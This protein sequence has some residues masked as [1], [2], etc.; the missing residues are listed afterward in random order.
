MKKNS[1]H[2]KMPLSSNFIVAKGSERDNLKITLA[3]K[4][5]ARKNPLGFKGFKSINEEK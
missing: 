3:G 4:K 1:P 5:N 2:P